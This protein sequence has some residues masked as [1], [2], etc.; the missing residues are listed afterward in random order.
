MSVIYSWIFG[1]VN[2][3]DEEFD[4]HQRHLKYLTNEYIKQNNI[5]LNPY[6]I[7]VPKHPPKFVRQK[8]V[9][10]HKKKKKKKKN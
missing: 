10:V 3:E 4:N 8:G 7:I 2:Q 1:Y 5:K 9:Y 6:T